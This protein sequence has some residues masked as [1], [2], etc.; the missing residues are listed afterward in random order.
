MNGATATQ[1]PDRA[2]SC[3]QSFRFERC[4]Q[5]S[6]L[7]WPRHKRH[8]A[9]CTVG[10]RMHV[11]LKMQM[12]PSERALQLLAKEVMTQRQRT[13]IHRSS[14]C[15]IQTLIGGSQ[16]HGWPVCPRLIRAPLL[17][18]PSNVAVR[19]CGGCFRNAK[20]LDSR[21][22]WPTPRSHRA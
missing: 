17:C 18:P 14:K 1:E 20:F 9:R 2:F 16:M 8:A 21:R 13:L 7:R 22:N 11:M 12:S 5:L 6:W 4:W 15:A 10:S 3:L 19:P